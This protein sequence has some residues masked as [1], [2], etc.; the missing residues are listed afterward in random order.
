MPRVTCDKGVHGTMNAA[1]LVHE[2]LVRKFQEWWII[3]NPYGP[4]VWNQTIGSKQLTLMLHM[5]NLLF[6]HVSS[7]IVTEHIKC[8]DGVHDTKDPLTV[9]RGKTHEHLGMTMD[10]S[11]SLGVAF[12][13]FD[14]AK[15]LWKSFLPELKSAC[16][17]TPAPESLFQLGRDSELL[18]SKQKEQHHHTTAKCLWLGQ[19]TRL[20]MQLT[21][22]FHCTRVKGPTREDWIK[23]KQLLGCVWKT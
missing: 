5:D 15:K 22:G 4:C 17:K 6:D 18:M 21:V 14:F 10:F 20:D 23:L 11:L 12:D 19:R 3:M 9:T 16:R 8:L 1:L 2:K 13:Q 7:C